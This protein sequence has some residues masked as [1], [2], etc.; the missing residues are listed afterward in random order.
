MN[1]HPDRKTE[2]PPEWSCGGYVYDDVGLEFT[3][4]TY[5]N[6]DYPIM[7]PPKPRYAGMLLEDEPIATL[8]WLRPEECP[9]HGS[10]RS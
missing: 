1:G 7:L 2:V 10:E 8:H 9:V 3:K 4:I 6:V 5:N